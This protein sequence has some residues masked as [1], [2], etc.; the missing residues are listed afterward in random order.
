[1]ER[2]PFNDG[3]LFTLN[4]QPEFSLTGM[5]LFSQGCIF[6]RSIA[7]GGSNAL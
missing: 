2:S 5:M 1:M 6:M 7:M 3:V 4:H